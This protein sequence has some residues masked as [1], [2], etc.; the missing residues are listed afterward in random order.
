MLPAAPHCRGGSCLIDSPAYRKMSETP[1]PPCDLC[2][3]PVLVSDFALLTIHGPKQFCCDACQG[4]YRML[5]E[6]EIVDEGCD[7]PAS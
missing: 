5:H 1:P 6:P 3:L 4:I 2:G 7:L